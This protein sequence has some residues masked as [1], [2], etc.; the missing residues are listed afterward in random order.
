MRR[1]P[2]AA[3][4]SRRPRHRHSAQIQH[5][6]QTRPARTRRD[7]IRM[8]LGSDTVSELQDGLPGEPW[9]QPVISGSAVER[10]PAADHVQ[11]AAAPANVWSSRPCSVRCETSAARPARGRGR[12]F[13]RQAHD[14]QPSVRS[15]LD[16]V[17]ALLSSRV[18]A[19][20]A[21]QDQNWMKRIGRP[22]EPFFSECRSPRSRR[23]SP[24]L[25]QGSAARCCQARIV[26]EERALD[27]VGER[28]NVLVGMER[29]LPAGDD[30]VVPRLETRSAPTPI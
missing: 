2:S 15:I 18:G 5:S 22:G 14:L 25:H 11:V 30:A 8:Q 20:S 29:P 1:Q 24:G 13:P 9:H 4:S 7:I 27:N 17:L 10:Q 19:S 6:A 16:A 3:P 26:M 21:R 23:S 12:R 28:L